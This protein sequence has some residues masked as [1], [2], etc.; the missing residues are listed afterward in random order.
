MQKLEKADWFEE[1]A[2]ELVIYLV[3]GSSSRTYDCWI[4]RYDIFCKNQS[5]I[6]QF[7]FHVEINEDCNREDIRKLAKKQFEYMIEKNGFL[8]D[9][10]IERLSILPYYVPPKFWVI[11]ING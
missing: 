3:C 6:E 8:I 9:D 5:K 7:N 10:V 2:R 11:Q 4:V 1:K